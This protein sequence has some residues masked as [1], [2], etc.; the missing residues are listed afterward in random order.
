MMIDPLASVLLR[1]PSDPSKRRLKLRFIAK[2]WLPLTFVAL[3]IRYSF[4]VLGIARLVT[5]RRSPIRRCAPTACGSTTSARSAG[6]TASADD[7][8]GVALPPAACARLREAKAR[9]DPTDRSPAVLVPQ[10]G[11]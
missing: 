8:R 3:G 9:D 2:A 4:V 7:R 1:L 11:R 6:P 10:S 5:G